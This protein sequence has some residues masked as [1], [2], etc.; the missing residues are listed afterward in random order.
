MSFC[1][2]T[3]VCQQQMRFCRPPF[4][5][6]PSL[7]VTVL[8]EIMPVW[9]RPSCDICMEEFSGASTHTPRLLTNCGHTFCHTCVQL[10]WYVVMSPPP[11]CANVSRTKINQHCGRGGVIW[12]SHSLLILVFVLAI[13]ILL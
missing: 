5:L 7:F 4:V 13:I 11:S 6:T 9:S 1:A 3:I 10:L 12:V 2:H 8:Q